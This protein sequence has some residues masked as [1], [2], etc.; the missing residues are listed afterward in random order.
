MH[1]ELKKLK[2]NPAL[3]IKSTFGGPKSSILAGISSENHPFLKDSPW[4]S[5]SLLI[6]FSRIRYIKHEHIQH[7]HTHIYIYMYNKLPTVRICK[8]HML[9]LRMEK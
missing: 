3:R 7:T 8:F 2:K 4:L 9:A 6:C 5:A 1:L